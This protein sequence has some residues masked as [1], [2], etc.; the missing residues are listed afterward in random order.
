MTAHEIAY[1]IALAFANGDPATRKRVGQNIRQC[2]LN[3]TIEYSTPSAQTF[4][5]A[6]VVVWVNDQYPE[7][8]GRLS[9]SDGRDVAPLKT[10]S[11]CVTEGADIVGAMG[12]PRPLPP[13]MDGFI[14]LIEKLESQLAEQGLEL[15][16][17]RRIEA[18]QKE[19]SIRNRIS[20]GIRHPK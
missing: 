17:L 14:R 6:A 20:G 11:A 1:S 13:D 3:G 12:R 16:R 9:H 15:E 5:E 19:I 10:G 18:K 4:S 8:A 7:V 2:L